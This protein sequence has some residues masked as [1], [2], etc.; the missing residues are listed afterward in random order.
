MMPVIFDSGVGNL[1]L[2]YDAGHAVKYD[3]KI[4]FVL[5]RGHNKNVKS[6]ID[7]FEL[8]DGYMLSKLKFLP[9]PSNLRSVS[10]SDI[11]SVG[12]YVLANAVD[13]TNG[14]R[15]R[16]MQVL[17][18]KNTEFDIIRSGFKQ[19]NTK[20]FPGEIWND[21]CFDINFIENSGKLIAVF[22]GS[23]SAVAS[24][25]MNTIVTTTELW[26]KINN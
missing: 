10:Y 21:W 11:A 6:G 12:D 19:S 13:T 9:G 20:P 22:G 4:F 23:S 14:W 5:G 26:N 3:N 16:H 1:K 7:V 25:T 8:R 2:Y 17:S 24:P 18:I 15:G